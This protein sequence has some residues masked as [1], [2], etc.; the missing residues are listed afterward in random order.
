VCVVVKR[1]STDFSAT[2]N[3]YYCKGFI[4]ICSHQDLRMSWEVCKMSMWVGNGS[5]CHVFASFWLT[6]YFIFFCTAF[7]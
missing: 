1:N 3:R 7:F 4:K 6:H 2:N 5:L